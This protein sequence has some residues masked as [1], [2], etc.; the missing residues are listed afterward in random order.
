MAQ[1]QSIFIPKPSP[2]SAFAGAALVLRPGAPGPL[3]PNIFLDW[4]SLYAA[5]LLTDGPVIIQYD[6]TYAATNIEPAGAYAFRPDTTHRGFPKFDP[7]GTEPGVDVFIADGVTFS[8]ETLNLENGCKFISLSSAPI[9]EVLPGDGFVIVDVGLSSL[10]R[11][12]GTAPF[13]RNSAPFTGSD[14]LFLIIDGGTLETGTDAVVDFADATPDPVLIGFV[15]LSGAILQEDTISGSGV[16]LPNILIYS[17]ETEFSFVQTGFSSLAGTLG[18]IGY[19]NLSRTLWNPRESA[20]AALTGE[21]QDFIRV[22]ASGGTTFLPR[23]EELQPGVVTRFQNA[24]AIPLS[25]TISTDGTTPDTLNGISGAYN[26]ESLPGDELELVS[27]GVSNWA[28]KIVGGRCCS[29]FINGGRLE[30]GGPGVV[31]IV[32]PVAA[33]SATGRFDLFSS[34]SVSADITASGAG[35][36]D[37]GAEAPDTWYAVYLLIDISGTNPPAAIL[38]TSFVGP[39]LPAGYNEWRRVGVVR[40]DSASDFIP[41]RQVWDDRVRRYYYD[42][43]PADTEVLSGGAAG[44]FTN[45]DLSAFVPPTA[46]NANVLASFATG[47]LGAPTDELL[48]RPDGTLAD[49]SLWRYRPGVVSDTPTFEQFELACP[50]Q[51]IEYHVSAAVNLA[52]I[53]VVGFDDELTT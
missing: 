42:A 2:G 15:V 14:A 10:L 8:F 30:Y 29:E 13:F 31:D 52:S 23:I 50:G 43:D 53:S 20:G 27:D 7:A 1:A 44:V 40:N 25:H 38:S 47:A 37:T 46:I 9:M 11:A 32:G 26:W 48:L 36:L 21:P 18:T 6:N 45:V 12:D 4:A 39:T 24:S 35:G 33:R 34:G 49:P 41:F 3:A 17:D 16:A 22:T 5:Y 28:M 19:L 51:I